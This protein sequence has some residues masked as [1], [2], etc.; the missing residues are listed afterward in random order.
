MG[1]K[2]T[3][4]DLLLLRVKALEER[5]ER[6]TTHKDS[7]S[8]ADHF[9][10]HTPKKRRM[11]GE[12]N[13]SALLEPPST[14]RRLMDFIS[15]A[16]RST[17][18]I[19][20]AP[21]FGTLSRPVAAAV[22]ISVTL[23]LPRSTDSTIEAPQASRYRRSAPPI[24]R[25]STHKQARRDTGISRL[26]TPI[27]HPPRQREPLQPPSSSATSTT[28]PSSAAMSTPSLASS[29]SNRLYP[30]LDPPLSQRTSAIQS[31]FNPPST[32]SSVSPI[33]VPR[34]SSST[35]S[36]KDL[37]RSFEDQGVLLQKLEKQHTGSSVRSEW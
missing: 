10:A 28:A 33:Q 1:F 27:T 11:G 26:P 19:P 4:R 8:A 12:H 3:N 23:P 13:S 31:L 24:S 37:V 35:S 18:V 34:K 36:V 22:P 5:A 25:T 29:S 32:C 30:A 7:M 9:E 6:R 14:V 2:L 15:S 21:S 16:F 20:T 17:A